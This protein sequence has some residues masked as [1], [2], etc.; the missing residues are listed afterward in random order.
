MLLSINYGKRQFDVDVKEGPG[1]NLAV[2]VHPDLRI[3]AKAPIGFDEKVIWQRLKKK[4]SWIAKQID[5]FL[6]FHPLSPERKYVSGETHYYLGRQYR[7]KIKQAKSPQLKLIGGFFVIGL[8]DIHNNEQ[9]KKLTQNWYAEHAINILQKR[10]AKHL[11]QFVKLG[12][13]EPT[14]KFKRMKKRWG[15]YSNKGII[16]LNL[17]LIKTP[18]HCIDYVIIHELCHSVFTKHDNK[19]YLL[20]KKML[21][22]WEKCKNRLEKYG[23]SI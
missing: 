22:D 10:F 5:Y 6:E 14:V 11:P 16:V 8:P 1:K 21:P 23:H 4:A 15:S 18:T 19:F 17:D 20:L 2:T 12:T 13:K 7:L 9:A 3:T